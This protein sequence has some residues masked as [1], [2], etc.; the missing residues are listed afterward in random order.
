[1]AVVHD[2]I[3]AA[4]CDVVV[5]ATSNEFDGRAGVLFRDSLGKMIQIGC[6]ILID[7]AAFAGSIV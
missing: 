2:W 5:R 4:H 6:S 7:T 3:V 1:M